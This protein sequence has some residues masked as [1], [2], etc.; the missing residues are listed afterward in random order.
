[1]G[2]IAGWLVLLG[3]GT[4]CGSWYGSEISGILIAGLLAS[5][6]AGALCEWLLP[7]PGSTWGGALVSLLATFIPDW[8]FFL[9][10]LAFEAGSDSEASSRLPG[11]SV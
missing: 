8:L 7:A 2:R 3:L 1:M 6:A 9:P 10:A 11:Q 5:V 4:L